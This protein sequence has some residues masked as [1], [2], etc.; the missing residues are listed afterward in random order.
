MKY[1]NVANRKVTKKQNFPQSCTS[2]AHLY[3]MFANENKIV[4]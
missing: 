4:W 1:K 3:S 2:I